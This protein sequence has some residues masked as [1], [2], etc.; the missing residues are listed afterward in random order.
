MRRSFV[1]PEGSRRPFETTGGAVG[2]QRVSMGKVGRDDRLPGLAM[3]PRAGGGWRGRGPDGSG[4][5][6]SGAG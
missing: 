6:G 2:G 3:E 4:L 5:D 1:R